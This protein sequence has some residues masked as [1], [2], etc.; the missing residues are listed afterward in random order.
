SFARPHRP[1]AVLRL[2]VGVFASRDRVLG[3]LPRT[4]ARPAAARSPLPASV[5]RRLA[6]PLAVLSHHVGGWAHQASWRPLL[7]R[8]YLSRLPLRD[9][10]APQPA[11]LVHAPAARVV[12]EAQRALQPLRGARRAVHAL[13]AAAPSGGG[14]RVDRALPN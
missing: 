11:E 12:P 1:A 5:D 9:P 7:A 14:R 13:W 3:D 6:P 4:A 2:R 8:P 10:T